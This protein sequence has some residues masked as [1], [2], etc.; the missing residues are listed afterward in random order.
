MGGATFAVSIT[1]YLQVVQSLKH[2]GSSKSRNGEINIGNE[3][4]KKINMEM[5]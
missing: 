5:N 4:M 3:G 2:A 1:D